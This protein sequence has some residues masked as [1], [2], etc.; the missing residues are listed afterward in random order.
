MCCIQ[1]SFNS[2][3]VAFTLFYNS[4]KLGEWSLIYMGTTFNYIFFLHKSYILLE[5][6]RVERRDVMRLS[7]RHNSTDSISPYRYIFLWLPCP[8]LSYAISCLICTIASRTWFGTY[9]HCVIFL[10]VSWHFRRRNVRC[11]HIPNIVLHPR[12][13][14][15]TDSPEVCR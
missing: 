15:T 5:E 14:R 6:C 2:R 1:W 8:I 11:R 3:L 12:D 10:W 9:L 7:T 4:R 13:D